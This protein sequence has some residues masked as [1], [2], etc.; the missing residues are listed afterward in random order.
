M[1]N[2]VVVLTVLV[3]Y[4]ILLLM[5]SRYRSSSNTDNDAFFRAGRRSHWLMVAFGMIGASVSGVSFVSVP[6]WVDRTGMT[7]LQMC[8]GFFFGYLVIAFVLLPLYYSLR[9][10][11]IYDYLRQ[12]FGSRSHI[13]GAAFFIVSKFLGA[14]ARLYLACLVLHEILCRPFGIPFPLTAVV[15]LCGIFIYTH[16]SGIHSIVRTDALQTACM[17][18]ALVGML[19][20]A[21]NTLNFSLS[22]TWQYVV[23]SDMCRVFSWDW[24]DSQ[25]FW[26]QFLS[27]MFITIVMTGLDQDM[28]QKNLTCSNLRSAQ[29]DMCSYGFCFLPVNLLFLLLGI[30]LYAVAQQ[31]GVDVSEIRGDRLMPFLVNNG[32]LG[33]LVII[34]FALGIASA[35]FSSA[36]SAMTALTTSICVDLLGIERRGC[37]QNR[38]ERQRKQVHVAVLLA[39]WFCI[40][41]F[42]V[43]QSDSIIDLVYVMAGYTYGPLL[44][45]FAFGLFTKRLVR[46][47]Y[48]PIVAVVSPVICAVLDHFAP[49]WWG[50]HFGYE[51]L[52]FNGLLTMLGC[53]ALTIRSRDTKSV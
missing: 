40:V 5:L 13:T 42:Y 38:A 49:L 44:G 10:T 3:L 20:F 21:M 28:M 43:L 8:L 31:S 15:M 14:G 24:H 7:Y 45:L 27:G 16:R 48:I 2:A 32:F 35:A 18:L 36:D 29:K 23:Q 4:F 53:W 34:P 1:T 6:G 41:S 33:Q 17:L 19:G 39:M 51:L 12:R 52:M 25:Y 50:Y 9:L 47:A 37:A 11:S 46:D 30:L 22:E 26:R